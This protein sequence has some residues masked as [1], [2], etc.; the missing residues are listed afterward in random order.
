MS[1]HETKW[2]STENAFKEV[3]GLYSIRGTHVIAGPLMGTCHSEDK[4]SMIENNRNP[5]RCE[6][7][8]ME[9]YRK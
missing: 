8:Q 5:R 7:K 6:K 2:N 9:T 4:N 3:K 1:W